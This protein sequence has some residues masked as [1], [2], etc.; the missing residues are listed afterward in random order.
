MLD[1]LPT[2]LPG[3]TKPGD[4][5]PVLAAAKQLLV[6]PR[7]PECDAG[8]QLEASAQCQELRQHKSK[9]LRWERLQHFSTMRI[10]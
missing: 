4:L 10:A 8:Q 5:E 1:D 2:P 3:L 9:G 7:V 6:S